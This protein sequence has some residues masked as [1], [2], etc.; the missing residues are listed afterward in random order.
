MNAGWWWILGLLAPFGLFG[1]VRVIAE[2]VAASRE[3]RRQ[4]RLVWGSRERVEAFETTLEDMIPKLFRFSYYDCYLSDDSSLS[5][6]E[7][8][9]PVSHSLD[10]LT[11]EYGIDPAALP[12]LKLVTICEAIATRRKTESLGER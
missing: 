7:P 9:Y 11:A 2:Q 8:E 10:R 12:D 1:I 3:H 4:P 5:D 6:F